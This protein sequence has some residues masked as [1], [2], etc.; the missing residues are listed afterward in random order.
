[1]H[2]FFTAKLLGDFGVGEETLDAAL[3][4]PDE[5]PWNEIAF[6]SGQYALQKF[7][8]DGG[9]NNGAHIHRVNKTRKED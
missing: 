4:A 1:V 3:Y 6:P 9:K 8:E 5:I 2:V 7:L